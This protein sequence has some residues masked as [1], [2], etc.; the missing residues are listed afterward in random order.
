MYLCTMQTNIANSSILFLLASCVLP[1]GILEY[2]DVVRVDEEP[3][4]KSD[5]LYTTILHIHLD[6]LDN[7]TDGMETF[8]SNGFTEASVIQDFPIRDRKVV[9]HVRR[10]RWINGQGKNTVLDVYPLMA[11]G[12]RYSQEFA[13]F[14]KEEA[15]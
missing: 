3:S 2:F 8:R 7:R 6:E 14:F 11:K 4:P 15:G 10:R 13:D 9:L 1:E 12:T 5:T